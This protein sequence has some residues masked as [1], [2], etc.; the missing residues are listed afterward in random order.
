VPACHHYCTI[1][2]RRYV[3]RALALYRSL[4]R[5]DPD[6]VLRAVCMDA[7]SRQLLERLALPRCRTVPIEH[8]ED[9]DPELRAVR[10]TRT[11]W[12]Y[13]WTA[14]PAVCRYFLQTE[15][16][17]EHLTYL[18]AD[19][20]I[21]SSPAPLFQ[22]LGDDSILL[23]PHRT[24]P[25][26]E[27]AVGIYNVGWLTFRNDPRAITALQWWRERCLDWCY[28]RVEP[29]RFGD[30]KYLDDWPTRFDGVRVSALPTAGLAPW[31]ETRHQTTP[32][33]QPGP[34]LIDNQPLIYFHHTGLRVERAS[35]LPRFL[36]RS[37]D[38]L[39]I[40][41]GRVTISYAFL[42]QRSVAV[43][44]ELVWRPYI[45]A[46]TEAI[47]D[48]AAIVSLEAIVEPPR[49]RLLLRQLLRR[50]LPVLASAYRRLPVGLRH[51]LWRSL[52]S[53]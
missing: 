15:P 14:T 40:H 6:F 47:A 16:Q 41:E 37:T 7:T 28:D 29:Q 48:L 51:R 9:W 43:I 44:T 24:S 53:P 2:D 39:E 23:I 34:P 11:S 3:A 19:L 8:I 22:E 21:W 27:N 50:R 38:E 5:S 36:A 35:W 26:T 49:H 17:L 42:S 46:L 25:D 20:Y 45:A 10:P 31:N 1:F 12:E 13:C 4:E 52:A 30:Q 18:D 33:P 32:N